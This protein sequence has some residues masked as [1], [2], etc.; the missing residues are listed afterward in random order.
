MRKNLFIRTQGL[1]RV[2]KIAENN[3]N[4]DSSTLLLPLL[5]VVDF[6]YLIKVLKFV[7][8]PFGSDVVGVKYRGGGGIAC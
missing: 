8:S 7:A 2:T 5:R 6:F 3:E 1:K 4:R